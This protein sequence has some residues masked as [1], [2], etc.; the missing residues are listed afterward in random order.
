MSPQ[1][2]EPVPPPK[3]GW[4]GRETWEVTA[5]W[6]TLM[7]AWFAWLLGVAWSHHVAARFTV[8]ATD[9]S[10]SLAQAGYVAE[11][12]MPFLVTTLIADWIA[13]LF[14]LSASASGRRTFGWWGAGI[15]WL[16]SVPLHG[17]HCCI[18]SIVAG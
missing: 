1:M 15:V 5:A 11:R 6:L 18:M 9:V 8:P 7:V 12:V 16:V 2:P 4:F 13:A 10:D 3:P 14:L 17:F